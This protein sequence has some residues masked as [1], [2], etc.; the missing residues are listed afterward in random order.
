MVI[1]A[2]TTSADSSSRA[3]QTAA[4]MRGGS[5]WAESAGTAARAATAISTQRSIARSLQEPARERGLAVSMGASL[6]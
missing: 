4:G 6:S 1:V 5:V 3:W 2:W